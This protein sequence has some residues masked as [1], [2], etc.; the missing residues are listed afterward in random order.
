MISIDLI[1]DAREISSFQLNSTYNLSDP[2][3]G[4]YGKCISC[5]KG[6]PGHYAFLDLGTYIIHPIFKKKILKELEKLCGY[7]GS[8]LPEKVPKNYKCSGCNIMVDSTLSSEL[9]TPEDI[10]RVFEN[11]DSKYCKYIIRNIVVP[12]PGIRPKDDM[13][14]PSDLSHA[15]SL[16]IKYISGYRKS[17]KSQDYRLNIER[18]YE[19]VISCAS[20]SMSGK[21]GIFRE[22]MKGKRLDKSARSVVVGDPEIFVDEIL[23]PKTMASKMTITDICHRYNSKLLKKLASEGKVFLHGVPIKPNSIVQGHK[24]ERNLIDGDY[25]LFNRQPS[26]SKDSLMSFKVRVR[27]DNTLAIGMN[28]IIAS[29]FNADFDGDEMNIFA[30]WEIHSQAELYSLC[31]VDNCEVMKPIQDTVVGEYLLKDSNIDRKTF[32]DCLSSV[33]ITSKEKGPI[34]G[35]FLLDCL[36]K[37][38]RTKY[39]HDLQIV[40]SRWL[41]TVG[42]NV[43]AY[44]CCWT[45]EDMDELDDFDNEDDMVEWSQRKCMESYKG[46][47]IYKMVKS[48]SKGN[49]INFSQIAGCVGYQYL[50]DEK[51]F[52]KSSYIK[53]LNPSEFITHSI[54]ARRGVINTGVQT[55]E[56]GYLNRRACHVIADCSIDY[57]GCLSEGDRIICFP[58]QTE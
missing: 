44:D 23:I 28:H 22:I 16:L 55:S 33:G 47:S 27:K 5:N 34:N 11:N 48:G 56:T 30:D 57:I 15:Y 13:E 40:V 19:K 7:C 58:R 6:C 31:C 43:S 26:L 17:K 49:I 1:G 8:P 51:E 50:K 53:G 9:L 32:M 54:A 4:G 29:A 18:Y 42:F 39:Y 24:Y 37:R 3:F 12:P 41:I 35:K 52:V 14:W 25:V 38:D 36:D 10:R 46:S 20:N 2:R 45:K 21:D